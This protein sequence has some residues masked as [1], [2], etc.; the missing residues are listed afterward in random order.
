[1][2]LST[3]VS[4]PDSPVAPPALPGL[5]ATAPEDGAARSPVLF[6]SLLPGPAQSIPPPARKTAAD[7]NPAGAEAAS[8]V[9]AAWLAMLAPVTVPSGEIAGEGQPGGGES[10]SSG[11]VSGGDGTNTVSNQAFFIGGPMIFRAPSGPSPVA[12]TPP[13]AAANPPGPIPLPASLLTTASGENLAAPTPGD[14]AATNVATQKLATVPAGAASAVPAL[15]EAGVAEQLA[16]AAAQRFANRSPAAGSAPTRKEK[17]TILGAEKFADLA[18]KSAPGPIEALTAGDKKI[19]NVNLKQVTEQVPSIG[20]GNAI[21]GL[22]PTTTHASLSGSTAPVS[23]PLS[24][25]L[26]PVPFAAPPVSG[27]DLSLLAHRAVDAV[28]TATEHLGTANRSTV[29]LQFSVG[30]A[31]LSVQVELRAGQIHT[32]FRTDS[33]DL[34]SALASEWQALNGDSGRAVRLADPIF[35]PATTTPDNAGFGEGAAGQRQSG[36]RASAENLQT[37]G[38]FSVAP[39]SGPAE[40]AA[41]E[42][43]PAPLRPD[44]NL[45]TFA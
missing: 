26:Q 28:M 37:S 34:R 33:S 29:R 13:K 38:S 8:A 7:S 23:A 6:D 18:A 43:R 5:P 39:R 9:W 32:T 4:S 14:P 25:Q 30:D 12:G 45:Y 17:G 31:N 1:M 15:A 41:S 40:S 2:Q 22:V 10:P 11:G 35:A 36:G 21:P 42:R 19:L 20:T 3:S 27:A 16:S 24:A 44:L